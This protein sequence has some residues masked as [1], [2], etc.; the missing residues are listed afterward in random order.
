MVKL[1]TVVSLYGMEGCPIF[2]ILCKIDFS[3]GSL[4]SID[5]F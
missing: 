4:G 3:T 5:V 2:L 1:L